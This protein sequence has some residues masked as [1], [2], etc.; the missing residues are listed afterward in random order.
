MDGYTYNLS[1]H[2]SI[3]CTAHRPTSP[4]LQYVLDKELSRLVTAP[5]ERARGGVEET[6][7]L[8][9]C[10]PCGK[11]GWGHILLHLLRIGQCCSVSCM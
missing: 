6:K 8:A 1:F 3:S 2:C 10:F 5:D 11:L 7:L 9:D 4:L